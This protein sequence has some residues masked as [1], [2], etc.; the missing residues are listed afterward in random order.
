MSALV[1]AWSESIPLRDDCWRYP[2]IETCNTTQMQGTRLDYPSRGGN[3]GAACPEAIAQAAVGC[4]AVWLL[5]WVRC[6]WFGKEPRGSAQ[7]V[8]NHPKTT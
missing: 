1:E 7:L 6:P 2:N 4:S 8:R 3:P 5:C